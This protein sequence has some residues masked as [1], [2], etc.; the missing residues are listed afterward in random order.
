MS[1]PDLSAYFSLAKDAK[2][3]PFEEARRLIKRLERLKT[4][5]DKTVLLWRQQGEEAEHNDEELKEG[6][7]SGGQKEKTSFVVKFLRSK[8]PPNSTLLFL[9]VCC[10]PETLSFSFL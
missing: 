9:F 5:D 7:V 10:Y 4:S 2:A 6:P 8:T 1:A 3:W